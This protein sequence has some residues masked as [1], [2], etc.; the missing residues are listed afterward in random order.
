M[1]KSRTEL[2]LAKYI[3]RKRQTKMQLN[4]YTP[5]LPN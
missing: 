2:Y 3:M 4:F 5:K 1:A